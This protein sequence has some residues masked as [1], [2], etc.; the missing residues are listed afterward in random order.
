MKIVIF[1]GGTGKRFWPASRIK[2]PKQFLPIVNDKPLVRL[3]YEILRTG[4]SDSDI[5]ISTGKQYESEVKAI[6]PE[7]PEENFILEPEM[8]DTSPAVTLA[9]SYLNKKF[10]GKV[11]SI[12]W[13]DHLIKNP[14][15]FI[16]CLKE[17]EEEV[18][19]T[20]KTILVVVPARFPSPHRG[21]IEFAEP[22]REMNENLS[23]RKF[24]RFVEKPSKE[25]AE[26]YIE[27]GNYGWNPGYWTLLPD[28][29]LKTVSETATETY[30]ICQDIVNTDFSTEALEKFK[31]CE[32][33]SADYAFAEYIKSDDALVMLTDM[34]WS[35]VGEWIAF[36]EA[37]ETSQEENVKVGNSFDL[38]SH[39]TLIYNTEPNKLIATI[40]LDGMVVVNTKDVVAIF[41]KH[42]NTRLK[43]FIKK[44][45]EHGLENYL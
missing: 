24:V 32:K 10:P 9:V 21:Y 28:Y 42:D 35:D 16:E 43:E 22:I 5:F 31:T 41:H 7:L 17:S 2:A 34:G 38:D 1:A 27:S 14:E 36:K 11:V 4:F 18:K 8:R 20:K 12:Q 44:L 26:K 40:G 13:S 37:L 19:K 6:L 15:V 39:D 45:E 30:K 25:L 23:L 3:R 29:Y 33:T